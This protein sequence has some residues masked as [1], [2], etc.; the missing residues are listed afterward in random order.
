MNRKE[1]I[2]GNIYNSSILVVEDEHFIRMLVIQALTSLGFGTIHEATDGQ[3]A[4]RLLE[5]EEIDIVLSD[6]EMEPMN[7]L[8]L[9]KRIRMGETLAPR[10]CVVIFLTGLSDVSTLASISHLDVHGF[11][12]KPISAKLLLDK[13]Q[14]ALCTRIDL[15][16]PAVYDSLIFAPADVMM[17]EGDKDDA[18]LVIKGRGKTA[19]RYT[20]TTKSNHSQPKPAVHND[21]SPVQAQTGPAT[22]SL[23]IASL[24]AGMVLQQDVFSRGILMMKKDSILTAGHVR[25]LRDVQSVLD[26]DRIEVLAP[27]D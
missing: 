25:V 3:E 7:G 22:M 1:Q 17:D 4:L 11:L 14:D 2:G 26:C 10:D 5:K 16:E 18:N 15:K 24:Q 19:P 8:D 12:I 21:T 9:V 6:I 27:P 20:V 23:P 13:I